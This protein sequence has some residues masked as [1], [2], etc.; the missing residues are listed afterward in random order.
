VFLC[1]KLTV[2]ILLLIVQPDLNNLQMYPAKK[3]FFFC[4]VYILVF[5]QQEPILNSGFRPR[6]PKNV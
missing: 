1:I 2:N 3:I 5:L 6:F 4:R